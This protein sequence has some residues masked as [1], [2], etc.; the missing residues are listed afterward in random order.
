MLKASS[1]DISITRMMSGLVL[2]RVTGCQELKSSQVSGN[3]WL[4]CNKKR[5]WMAVS[6]SI[7][8][9]ELGVLKREGARSW[10]ESVGNRKTYVCV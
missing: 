1:V 10:N 2:E 6:L 5:D 9:S 4:I 7:G 8:E 3:D